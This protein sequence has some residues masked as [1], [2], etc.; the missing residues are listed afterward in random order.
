M[1]NP[2]LTTFN[3]DGVLVFGYQDVTIGAQLF[4][5]EEGE[6][7]F[8]SDWTVTNNSVAV[9]NKQFGRATVPTGRFTLQIPASVSAPA[10]FTT[11]TAVTLN[12]RHSDERSTPDLE[13]KMI[14]SHAGTV[15]R[16]G[17]PLFLS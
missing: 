8:G 5:V 16:P 14:S 7:T 15:G 13:P 12:G 3:A 6:L 1:P 10:L 11:F 4:V 17:F 9:P 2:A